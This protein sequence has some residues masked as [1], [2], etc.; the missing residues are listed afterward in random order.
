MSDTDL[1]SRDIEQIEANV[2]AVMNGELNDFMDA[3]LKMNLR[4]SGLWIFL[5]LRQCFVCF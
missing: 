1:T 4:I 3:Y 2:D 5:N